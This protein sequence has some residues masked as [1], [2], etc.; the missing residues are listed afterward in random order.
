MDAVQLTQ[1]LVAF[2]STS[3]L[4]NVP[5][6]DYVD[7]R[8]QSLGFLTERIEYTDPQGVA[9]ANVVGKKGDGQ[10][11][12]AYFGHTDVV[13]ADPWFSDD[14]GP[15][16]PTV[17]DDRLYGRGS[18][19]MKGS[20]AAML[21]AAERFAG[22]DLKKPLY[23]TCT[24]DEEIG[25]GGAQQVASRSKLYREMVAGETSGIIGE[26]TLLNVVYA[27][28]GTYGFRATSRGRAAHSSTNEGLNANL[29]MIPF[30]A[31]MK[32]I[33]ELTESDPQ[34]LNEE[35]Q[36]PSITWNI[37]INDHTAAVNITPPQSVCTVYFRPMPG[38]DP[39]TLIARCQ[40]AAEQNGIELEMRVRGTPLYVD[41]QSPFVR[42]V[43]E[44]A[45]Q[46]TPQT[47]AYG[48][49]GV[50]FTELK[51]CV[52]FGPGSIQQAHTHDEWVELDQLSAGTDAYAR[53][54]E[55]W[56]C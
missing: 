20:V 27:H 14:H 35:F 23:I 50:M 2:E 51:K 21:A 1:D 39:E 19:D 33:R 17:K 3:S 38:Q 37:G 49:D 6:T 7:D 41:P 54:I 56:C 34:W 46:T 10:G 25:Y 12:M 40:A 32:A 44:L 5:V 11:G 13:P 52:V 22:Q 8:L 55:H 18:C 48:T 4:S 43:L 28:K 45:G 31:E 47:V 36:P 26:P 53:M 16:E 42:E 24:S 15:F 9:K 29:A 30:L